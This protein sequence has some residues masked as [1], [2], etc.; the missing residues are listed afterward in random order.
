MANQ[1][2]MHIP[3]TRRFQFWEYHVSHGMALIRSPRTE[4]TLS[5]IDIILAGVEYLALPR[6]L[7]GLQVQEALPSEVERVEMILA[8]EVVPDRVWAL[9][10]NNTRHIVVAAQLVVR[11]SNMEIFESPFDED[12]SAER[13]QPG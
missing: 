7:G 6:H 5:N 4:E 1:E 3:E 11:E 10:C 12:P 13:V 2:S 8:R 9:V